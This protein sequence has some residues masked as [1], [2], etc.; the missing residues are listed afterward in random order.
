MLKLTKSHLQ[1]DETDSSTI[2]ACKCRSKLL[3]KCF[4]DI[5]LV[6]L[7]GDVALVNS[8]DKTMCSNRILL[9]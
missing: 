5:S 3:R 6:T 4:E 7:T 1:G 8:H 9:W 2:L